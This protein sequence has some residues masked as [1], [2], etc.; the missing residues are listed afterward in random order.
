[1][2]DNKATAAAMQGDEK[3]EAE[4][5]PTEKI[6]G[7][8]PTGSLIPGAENPDSPEIKEEKSPNSE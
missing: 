1:M 5:S 6:E 8:K 3:S 4:K 2:S 7:E